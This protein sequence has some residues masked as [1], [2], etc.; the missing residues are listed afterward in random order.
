MKKSDTIKILGM[1][2][3]AYPNMKEINEIQVE[4]WHE[5]LKDIDKDAALVAIK[6]N[7]LE[8]PYPPTIA[9]IRKQ[10]VEVSTPKQLDASEAW[11]EVMQAIKS[12]GYY[13]E[14]E[15]MESMSPVA[16]RTAKYMGWQEICHSEKPDVIR[17]QFLKMYGT[18]VERE[19]Q[20]RLLPQE[21]KGEMKALTEKLG[22]QFSLRGEAQ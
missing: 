16:A 19:Y 4:I 3:A 9:D 11:G 5:C 1:L 18:V 12:Y 6:K 13:R 21:L 7:I 10:V 8:S 2:A 17:G 20:E 14:K 22:N 15:A